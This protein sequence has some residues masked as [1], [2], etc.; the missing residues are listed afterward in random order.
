MSVC[1]NVTNQALLIVWS[2]HTTQFKVSIKILGKII[3][4]KD[5]KLLLCLSHQ[6]AYEAPAH[7]PNGKD[8]DS[9]GVHEGRRLVRH[10]HSVRTL[11]VRF[12]NKFLYD[13]QM[14]TIKDPMLRNYES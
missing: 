5:S 11:T 6:L 1:M 10:V 14:N 3:L 12:S 7:A 2:S 13:L 4:V 8:G 9:D